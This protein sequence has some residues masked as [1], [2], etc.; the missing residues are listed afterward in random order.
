MSA[1]RESN[2]LPGKI[3]NTIV[4]VH[5]A[6][7]NAKNPASNLIIG[8]RLL[9]LIRARIPEILLDSGG[10]SFRELIAGLTRP[11]ISNCEN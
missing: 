6:V 10:I 7:P 4:R 11:E 2:G 3:S 1:Q 5:I 9:K 8:V